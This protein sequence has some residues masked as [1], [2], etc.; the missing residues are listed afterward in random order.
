MTVGE[1]ARRIGLLGVIALMMAITSSAFLA[2]D[3]GPPGADAPEAAA[4]ARAYAAPPAAGSTPPPA[5]SEPPA[6]RVDFGAGLA[7]AE[8]AAGDSVDLGVAVMDLRTGDLFGSGGEKQYYSASLSKLLLVVDVLDRR[9]AGELELS[10]DGLGLV[11]R[12]LS[13]S[14]DGAMDAMWTLFD[15]MGA[16][17]R[18]AQRAGMTGTH[19][20]DDPSQWGEVVVT[21]DDMVRLY[22]HVLGGGLGAADR[23]L[24]VDALAAARQEA[25]DGFDQFFG[26]LDGAAR[27]D[28]T[29]YAKQGWMHY[30]P[31]DVYLHSAGVVEGRYAIAVLTV[32]SGVST[33]TARSRVADVVSAV[34]TPLPTT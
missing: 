23:D 34:L 28:R 21:A 11:E 26:L 22:H 9:E 8:A 33:D 3:T 14:D 30:L 6:A 24:V 31:N 5:S 29:A 16:V 7:A 15:G 20:P 18:V 10:D 32:H 17:E 12:A 2:H 19:P 25:A 1:R 4:D 13:Y 27:G